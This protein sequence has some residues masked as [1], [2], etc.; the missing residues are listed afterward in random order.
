MPE[1]LIMHLEDV[2]PFEVMTKM[3][4]YFVEQKDSDEDIK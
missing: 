2:T 1:I 3:N 4:V